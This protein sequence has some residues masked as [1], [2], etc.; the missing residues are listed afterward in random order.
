MSGWPQAQLR[1]FQM[2]YSGATMA[3]GPLQVLG[4]TDQDRSRAAGISLEDGRRGD[5]ESTANG[6]DCGAGAVRSRA[7]RPSCSISTS[8]RSSRPSM[9]CC[10]SRSPRWREARRSSSSYPS[11]AA[12]KLQKTWAA[13]GRISFVEDRPEQRLDGL[14]GVLHG[15]QV[16]ITQDNLEGQAAFSQTA[17][18]C[19]RPDRSAVPQS[20]PRVRR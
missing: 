15:E 11:N 18:D 10:P 2:N 3:Y 7:R 6:V 1:Q 8:L 14:E 13:D 4:T 16:A 19:A 12:R 20:I 17:A 5:P 9:M